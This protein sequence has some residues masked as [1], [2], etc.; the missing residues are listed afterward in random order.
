[1]TRNPGSREAIVAG[2]RCPRLDNG[3]GNVELAQARGG[4]WIDSA[5]P[6]H[7]DGGSEPAVMPS[8]PGSR[9]I[10]PEAA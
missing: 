9:P 6:L 4:W 7:G 10:E 2:C 1:M 8:Q 5:C 3:H